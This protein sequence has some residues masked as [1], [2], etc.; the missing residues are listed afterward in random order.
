MRKKYTYLIATALFAGIFFLLNSAFPKYTAFIPL[1]LVPVI[2]D[3]YLWNSISKKLSGFLKPEKPQDS[4]SKGLTG[5]KWV[6]YLITGLYWSPLML[7][8]SSILTGMMIPFTEWNIAWRTY[9]LGFIFITYVSKFIVILFLFLADTLRGFLFIY[10]RF[11]HKSERS[12]SELGRSRLLVIP[13]W[14]TGTLFFLLSLWGIIY[15]NFDF[16]VRKETIN[17]PELPSS[18]NGLKIIQVSDIHLGS[19]VSANE[20]RKAVEMINV[21]KPDIVFFTGDMVNYTSYETFPYINIL[22]EIHAPMGIYAI[23][24]NHDYGDYVK[25]SSVRKKIENREYLEQ[26]YKYL[27]WRLL[28]NENVVLRRNND[29]IELIGVENW[30][31]TRRF[32]RLGDLE[33]ATRGT[34]NLSVQILLT[35]DPSHWD[36]LVTQK[37]KNID[38]TFSGHTHG[39]QLG[40]ECCGIRWSP[41]RYLYKEWAGLY[42]SPVPGSHP[43]YLYVNRGLGSLGYPGRIGILP[44][45]TLITLKKRNGEIA[46]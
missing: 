40:I 15:W 28:M 14:I 43:Q 8:A 39:F 3:I 38:V 24:G 27:G 9:V 33:K 1:F 34:G 46:N 44:E 2:L 19:W 32:P 29:S 5:Y 41:A 26:V 17:L 12:Y 35:H 22:K 13:G 45:I 23:L 37:Y 18:F 20:L 4:S 7:L 25:W 36:R 42:T 31:G 21:E 30:G 10:A 11:H 16:T 6:A